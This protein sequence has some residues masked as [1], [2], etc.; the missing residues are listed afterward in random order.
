MQ[1]VNTASASLGGTWGQCFFAAHTG[2]RN[3]YL[4]CSR[5]PEKKKMKDIK[6]ILLLTLISTALSTAALFGLCQAAENRSTYEV[7]A[8]LPTHKSD[9]GEPALQR[10]ERLRDIASAVDGA[11]LDATERAALISLGS[12]ESH[13]SRTVC[14]GEQLGD[15]G[16]AFGCWQ[17]H[18]PDRSGGVSGQARRAIA[19]L[20]RAGNYC[21]DESQDYWRGAF[22][23]YATG[24]TCDWAGA[25]ERVLMMRRIGWRL[26]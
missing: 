5:Q 16:R 24:K 11:T 23:L 22:S 20:K 6:S 4:G 17:S 15:G 3:S 8:S 21:R 10:A 25:K 19:Q 26:R 2:L 13:F 14:S 9:A 12:H 18:H 7:L 1:G